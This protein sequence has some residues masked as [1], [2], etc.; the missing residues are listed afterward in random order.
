MAARKAT[1]TEGSIAKD[2]AQE[3]SILTG[4]VLRARGLCPLVITRARD[5]GVLIGYLARYDR[6]NKDVELY[7]TRRLWNWREGRNTLHE[8]SQKGVISARISEPVPGPHAVLDVCEI[9][10][11][12]DEAAPLLLKSRWD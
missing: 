1:S 10:P 6:E 11:V 3:R 8:V 4:E 12:S 7:D 2:E 9:L 5:S